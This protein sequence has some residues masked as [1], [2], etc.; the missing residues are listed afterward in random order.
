MIGKNYMLVL[1]H[2]DFWN[3]NNHRLGSLT[4]KHL[5]L[6]FWEIQ[7]QGTCRFGVWWVPNF[8]F[9]NCGHLNMSSQDRE[10]ERALWNLFDKGTIP[11]MRAPLS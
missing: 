9:I 8:W 7:D 1:V 11:F 2:S 6:M 10:S 4:N 3:T 5:V